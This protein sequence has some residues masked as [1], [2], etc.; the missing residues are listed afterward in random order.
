MLDSSNIELMVA[1]T[2]VGLNVSVHLC[3]LVRFYTVRLFMLAQQ[4]RLIRRPM[5]KTD[6]D[7]SFHTAYPHSK[8]RDLSQN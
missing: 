6:L 5:G 7:L 8:R 3:S 2:G 1:V 4:H